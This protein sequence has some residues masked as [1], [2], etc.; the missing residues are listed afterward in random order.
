MIGALGCASCA[1]CG[2]A[3]EGS[4]VEVTARV[5]CGLAE[6]NFRA[7][8]GLT[9]GIDIRASL[10]RALVSPRHNMVTKAR[11]NGF[12]HFNDSDPNQ[13][14]VRANKCDTRQ[15]PRGQRSFPQ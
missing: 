2:V 14:D 3:G 7:D 5:R 8:V 9:C 1:S 12:S 15:T 6:S 11:C 4:F 13:L 10:L